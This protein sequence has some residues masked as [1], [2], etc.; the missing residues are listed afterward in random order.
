M[1]KLISSPAIVL[2]VMMAFLLWNCSKPCDIK[3]K[4]GT[5]GEIKVLT[6]ISGKESS[7]TL[8]PGEAFTV[9]KCTDCAD[10]SDEEIE[11]DQMLISLGLEELEMKDKKEVLKFLN[12][13][14]SEDCLVKIF[15]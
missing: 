13:L 6:K 14:K 8:K 4:N 7:T 9:G 12:E 1:K 11:V 15:Q 10:I 5:T 2:L 3:L